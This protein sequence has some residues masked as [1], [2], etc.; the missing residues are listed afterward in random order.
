MTTAQDGHEQS[1]TAPAESV[2]TGVDPRPFMEVLCEQPA[3]LAPIPERVAAGALLLDDAQPGWA[4]LI[5]LAKLRVHDCRACIVGQVYA[6]TV[7]GDEQTA[8]S[9]GLEA[10]FTPDDLA[11]L[12]GLGIPFGFHTRD[13]T[14]WG[15]LQVEWQELIERRQGLTA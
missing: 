7:T 1:N 13:N 15:R 5:D 12:W 14:E 8:F 2:N 9:A 10:L 3:A 6:A 4:D 11:D